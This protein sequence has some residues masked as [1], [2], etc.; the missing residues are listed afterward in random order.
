M[1][2]NTTFPSWLEV[3]RFKTYTLNLAVK[4]DESFLCQ[5]IEK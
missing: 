3:T 5:N 2:A 4:R 1:S